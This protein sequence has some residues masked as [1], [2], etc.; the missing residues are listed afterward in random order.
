MSGPP[1]CTSDVD[2]CTSSTLSGPPD[3]RTPGH[4]VPLA[5][6]PAAAH[7]P[8]PHCSPHT[9]PLGVL[10]AEQALASIATRIDGLDALMSARVLCGEV[11]RLS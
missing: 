9:E 5:G 3:C 8:T 2:I 11:A 4:S 10:S 7:S 6:V 1:A